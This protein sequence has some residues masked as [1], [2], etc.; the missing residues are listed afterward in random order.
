MQKDEDQSEYANAEGIAML[1]AID[2]QIK[3]VDLQAERAQE[4]HFFQEHPKLEQQLVGQWVAL[5][6]NEII[7]HGTD[8]SDV[9]RRVADAGH[10]NPF[11]TRVLDPAVTYVFY[12]LAISTCAGLPGRH[13]AC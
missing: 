2:A 1:S 12:S 11:V 8:L 3:P 5:D 7:S 6:G 10:P 13:R 9:V 4:L